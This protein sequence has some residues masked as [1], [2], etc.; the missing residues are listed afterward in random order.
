MYIEHFHWTKILR[1]ITKGKNELRCW[2]SQ[3]NHKVTDCSEIK[4]K[5][6]SEKIN[7]VKSKKLCFN[8]TSPVPLQSSDSPAPVNNETPENNI[9][10]Q[11][12]SQSI[13]NKTQVLPQVVPVTLIGNSCCLDTNALLDSGSDTTLIHKDIVK[14][15]GLKG[16]KREISISG[17]ISQTE[18]IK[19]EL[20]NVQN[21]NQLIISSSK[22]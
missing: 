17:A 12:S 8:K 22:I 13:Q 15:L 5:A 11:V 10:L 1:K 2:I 6:Y 14:N 4:S 7:L 20:I 16:E 18:K 9:Q 21:F 19:S 3:K